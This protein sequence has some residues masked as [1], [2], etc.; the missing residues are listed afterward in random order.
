MFAFG[1]LVRVVH[2]MRTKGIRYDEV[3]ISS[4]FGEQL[5]QRR[6]ENER[7]CDVRYIFLDDRRVGGKREHF[8]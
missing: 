8:D 6:W 5:F 2:I 1:P 3:H 4:R 7:E